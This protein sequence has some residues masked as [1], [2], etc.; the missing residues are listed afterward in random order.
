MR[1]SNCAE[2]NRDIP[3]GEMMFVVYWSVDI[4]A[5]EA[6]VYYICINCTRD[7]LREPMTPG[8]RI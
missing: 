8:G 2:C 5:N 6:P 7:Y 4:E 3:K 1:V